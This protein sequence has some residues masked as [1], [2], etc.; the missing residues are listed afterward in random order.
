TYHLYL[1]PGEELVAKAGGLHRFMNWKRNILT[2]SGG[3]QVFSLAKLRR[4]SDEGVYFNSHIDGSVHF[5][6]PEKVMQ[7]EQDLGADIAMCFD[8]CVEYPCSY[9]VAEEAV[10]RTTLWARRSR[11][12]HHR[13]DQALFGIVQGSVFKD[14]RIR[15]VEQLLELDFPGYGIGGLSV[16]EPHV[17][18]YNVLDAIRHILPMD[19]PRY[20]MG[21][22][23]APNLVEGV[24]RGVDMFDCVLPTRNGRNG[25][26]FTSRGHLNIKNL[27]FA[28]DFSPIDENC[29]CYVCRTFTR[30][31]LRHLYKAGEI[32]S[33]R[34]CTWHNIH[35]LVDLMKK[36]RLSILNGQFPEF[37]ERFLNEFLKGEV[38]DDC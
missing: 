3:F 6:S 5:L 11:D 7:I 4:I 23:F 18:M 30:S 33:S 34:L 19:K 27:C 2:D 14:L 31:Y 26:V 15:S 10:R 17:E 24:S 22:G 38:A 8:Q 13:E 36:A 9:E 37:K 28:D 21:V 32:L 1:R 35:F 16:G 25:S 12:S 20:L 29:D